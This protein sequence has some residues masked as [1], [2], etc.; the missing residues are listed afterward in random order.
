MELDLEGDA[1]DVAEKQAA[2]AGGQ[3]F[4]LAQIQ[5]KCAEQVRLEAEVAEL[6]SQLDE[7]QKQLR[8]ISE[9]EVPRM[10]DDLGIKIIG[11]DSGEKISIDE[12]ITASIGKGKAEEAFAWLRANGHGDLIKRNV[13]VE[14]GRGDDEKA[15]KLKAAIES[16]GFATKD[17]SDVHHMTLTSFVKE[18]MKKGVAIPKEALGV[19]IMRRTKITK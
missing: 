7:K 6:T 5:A 11:L 3:T 19:W 10:M 13:S 8:A 1:K 4:T 16:M 14:F 9:V 18:Q 17:K 12:K 2:I 15:A